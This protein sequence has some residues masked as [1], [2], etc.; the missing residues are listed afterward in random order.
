VQLF[1]SVS[2]KE[3]RN[4]MRKYYLMLEL[5]IFKYRW[6]NISVSWRLLYF[7]TGQRSCP[8]GAWDRAA[9]NLCN[10]RLH[11]SSSVASQQ[12]WPEPVRLPD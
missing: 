8:Q 3:L 12:S 9:V 1:L 4:F 11:R 5:F 2:V 6:Q 10:T 7:S